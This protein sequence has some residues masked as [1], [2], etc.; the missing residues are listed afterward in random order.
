MRRFHYCPICRKIPIYRTEVRTCGG[1]ECI[2]TW[3]SL[4]INQ[5]ARM[6][7]EAAELSNKALEAQLLQGL[8]PEEFSG[9]KADEIDWTSRPNVPQVP[10]NIPQTVQRDNEFLKKVWGDDAPGIVKDE[11]L[12]M[13]YGHIVGCKC[14]LCESIRKQTK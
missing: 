7:E 8:R 3:R 1:T 10:P 4:S 11:E 13:I 2:S 5:K 12:P 14:E 6:M 9:V